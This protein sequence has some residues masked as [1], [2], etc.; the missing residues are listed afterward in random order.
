MAMKEYT[1]REAPQGKEALALESNK[2]MITWDD[3]DARNVYAN[4]AQVKATRDEFMLLFGA[5]QTGHADQNDLRVQLNERI[6]LNP[7]TAKRLAIQLNKGIQAYESSFGFLDGKGVLHERLKP[8]PPL[9]PPT[10]KSA[11]GAEKVD[12]L[13]QFLEEQKVRPAFERSCEFLAKTLLENRFLLGFEKSMIG[14]N[15]NEK[16]MGVCVRMNMPEDFL[17]VFLGN[18]PEANIVGFG[19][20]EHGGTCIV[21][22]YLEF[23]VRFYRAIKS[24][25]H[26]PDPYLSHLGFKWDTENNTRKALAR[27][28][29]FPGYTTE[30]IQERL[31]DDFYGDKA[32]GPFEIVK[33]ILDLASS[34]V[35]KERFLYL[36]VKEEH[37]PRSSFDINV[38]GANLQLQEVYPFLLDMC[39]HYSI[40]EKQFLN[41]YEPAK[42]HILG[43]LAGGIDREG[44]DF[45]TLY[46]GE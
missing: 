24:K 41:L 5:S 7:V 36:D 2:K 27:Y 14:R 13:F 26:N 31:S 30:E 23:G 39:R 1:G 37:N 4:V 19:F 32:G 28:T 11:K 25:P 40:P 20:G 8:T 15:P 10:F 22:A 16:L 45:L 43:H 18:L 6:V 29:C 34:K 3:S 35:S 42:T 21:K 17:A 9:R 46:Y 12:L 44:R 33:G 38:Y